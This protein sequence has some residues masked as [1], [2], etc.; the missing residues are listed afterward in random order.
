MPGMNGLEVIEHLRADVQ[1][2]SIPII[3]LTG[4]A[5]PGDKE[6][7]LATGAT[8]YMS[9]PLKLKNLITIIQQCLNKSNHS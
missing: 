1:C 3:A 8:A 5:M 7:C 6:R 4:L 2:Q 9:K